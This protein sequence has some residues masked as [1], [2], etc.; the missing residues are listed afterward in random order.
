[1]TRLQT[2]LL[3]ALV[4]AVTV[5]LAG[6]AKVYVTQ[7]QFTQSLDRNVARATRTQSRLI[8]TTRQVKKLVDANHRTSARL[9]R[10]LCAQRNQLVQQVAQSQDFL[11]HPENFPQ[12]NDPAVLAS[13]AQSVDV[14]QKVIDALSGLACHD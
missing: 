8:E 2:V 9:N 11:N 14:E 4:V 5:G 7:R 10:A 13:V 12:F 1:M 3:W 6:G